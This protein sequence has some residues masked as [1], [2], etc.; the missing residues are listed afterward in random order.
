MSASCDKA[1][2]ISSLRFA[3]Y[4]GN[5]YT[6]LAKPDVLYSAHTPSN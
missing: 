2:S 3:R 6:I 1:F 4:R 5:S